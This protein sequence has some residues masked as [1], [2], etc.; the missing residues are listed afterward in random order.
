[1]TV[2]VSQAS[3]DERGKYVGGQAGNQSGTEL[4]TRAYYSSSGNPW[5]TYRA[6][7]A[8]TASKIANAAAQAVANMHIGYDQYERNTVRTQAMAVSWVMSAIKKDCEC[9]CTSLAATCCICAGLSDAALFKGGNLMYTGDAATKL[10]NAGMQR[11]GSGLAE[12]ALRLGDVLVRDGHCVVVTSAP[13][14]S[15]ST[16]TPSKPTTAVSGSIDELAQAVIAGRF[17]NGDSRRAALGDQYE[18]VQK[19]VNEMLTGTANAPGTSTGT[20][21]II[22][23]TYKVI[24]SSLNV[25]SAPSL[26]G[27]VVASYGYGDTINSIAADVVEKDGYTWAHY[28]AYSGATR[29]VAVGTSNGSEKYLAKC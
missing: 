9:D 23:G 25:R 14:Q 4:N 21:R 13:A 20:P 3:C 17:G 10:V 22:A 11:V 18:A 28:T 1:M 15:G 24:A 16:A 5:V 8:A 26:S 19:R 6:K 2:Y 27:S 12:S 7:D 29:Y